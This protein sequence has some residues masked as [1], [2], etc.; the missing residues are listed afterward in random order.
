MP[1]KGI[2]YSQ[3]F[4][5]IREILVVFGRKTG[6]LYSLPGADNPEFVQT[7]PAWSPDGKW[8]VFARATAD[9][10]VNIWEKYI[11]NKKVSIRSV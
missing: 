5:P 2:E 8:I 1:T 4:F 3:L 7:N 10:Y 11:E 9:E 6:A